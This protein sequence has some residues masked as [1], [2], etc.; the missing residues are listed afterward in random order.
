[1]KPWLEDLSEEWVPQPA[2]PAAAHNESSPVAT[3]TSQSVPP[4]PRS[5]L[6][7][8]RHSSGSFSEIQI[9]QVA[10]DVRPPKPRS[11]LAERSR[12]DDDNNTALTASPNA[13][14]APH[15]DQ[16]RSASPSVYASSTGSVVQC[17]TVAQKSTAPSPSKDQNT[18]E[19]RRR[20][21]GGDIGY[22]DQKD[23]FS[24]MGLQNIFQRPSTSAGVFEAPPER[25]GNLNL[26]KNTS[27]MPSSPPP[28][29]SDKQ[30][31]T[32][33]V[34]DDSENTQDDSQIHHRKGAPE[35]Q[36]R[37]DPARS[38]GPLMSDVE[39]A[40]NEGAPRTVSGQIEFENENFSPVYLTNL[41]I[42]AAADPSP[43]FRGSELARRLRHIG[44]PTPIVD[45]QP[46][47][48]GNSIS[49]A[50]TESSFSK[51]QD[52]TLP[53]DLPAGTP[54]LADVGGFVERQRG[55]YSRDNSFR[56]RPLS[57]SPQSKTVNRGKQRDASTSE[58]AL[59]ERSPALNPTRRP[60]E[61][62][63][64]ANS[65]ATP[66]RQN[67]STLL[68]PE[69]PQTAG[70]PLKLFD[71]HDTFTSKRL[72]RRLSQL[73]Y[74][75]ERAIS[76]GDNTESTKV[77]Q[78]TSRLTS[79]E[80]MSMHDILDAATPEVVENRRVETFG[81]GQL[82]GY[83]FPEEFSVFSSDDVTD[84]E[85]LL[86]D[87]PSM[88]VTP[89]GSRQQF[90]FQ[91]NGSQPSRK[92]SHSQRQGLV[93]VSNPF[94]AQGGAV[95]RPVRTRT[96]VIVPAKEL[97][98]HEFA[99]GKRGPTSP[100]KNPTPK[101]RRTL[102]REEEDEDEG[103]VFSD[104]GVGH[105]DNSHVATQS[106]ISRKRK[107][108]R[109]DHAV[110]VAGA[111][112]LAQR[113]ILRPR[114]PT[115][116]QRRLEGVHAEII[117]ATEAFIMSSPKLDT[118]REQLDPV[119]GPDAPSEET[120]AVIVANKV[121]EF[122]MKR[123]QVMRDESRKRSVTTQDFL[124]EAVKIMD[125]IRAK[126]RPTS[127]LEN[128]EETESESLFR[129]EADPEPS[130]PLTFS[131]P[132]SREGRLS[133]WR[134]PNKHELDPSVMS[135]L[136]KFQEKESEEFMGSSIRSLRFSQLKGPISPETDSI[137]VEQNNIRITDKLNR[138]N[139]E[140]P[141]TID[142]ADFHPRE[143]NTHAS[144]ASSLGQTMATNISRKSEH[145]A[146]VAPKAVAH[147]IP[148]QLAGMSYD[149]VNN[150]WFRQKSPTK[151][152]RP[153]EAV[154]T[155]NETEE[156]PFGNI[157]DLTVDET[158]EQLMSKTSPSRPQPTV[159]T[160]VE[161]TGLFE[162]ED[163]RPVTREG[164]NNAPTDTS[165]VPSKASNFGWSYPKTDTRAT[166][167]SEQDPRNGG[168][169]KT[170]QLPTTYPI[171][172]SDEAD[173]EHEIKYFEGRDE[174]TT[175]MPTAKVRDITFSIEQ[176]GLNQ[177]KWEPKHDSQAQGTMW[178]RVGGANSLPHSRKPIQAHAG[179][180][181]VLEESQPR[182]YRVQLSMSVS[183]PLLKRQDTL[184]PAPSSPAKG[185]VT[186]MLSDLPEFTMHQVDE[187][188]LPDRVVVKHDGVRFSKA[189]EDRYAQ[190][191]AELVKAL[192]NV[193]P[194]EPYWEDLRAVNLH[195][196][197]LSNLHRLD[198]FC[199]R[200]EELDV[201]DNTIS[202][203]EG[204]PYSVRRLRVQNNL[205][206]GLTS[207]A[208]LH[209]LQ[210]LDISDN[211]IDS[212]DGLNELVH[213]R[214]LKVDNNRIT[215]LEGVLHLDGL[216]ELSAGGNHVEAVDFMDSEL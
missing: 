68:S 171:P 215:S 73:E 79:L 61:N 45:I 88:D 104:A 49:Q 41:Q 174:A 56:T 188:E 187:C 136:Q 131:R 135:H 91:L 178:G 198:E 32:H 59:L 143:N 103:D 43:D 142:E 51:L 134:E 192:Q 139:I 205:L 50:R 130:S 147:L 146:Y 85:S 190:G 106:V 99:E 62:S 180:V 30:E 122:S 57:P 138:L 118:I 1:M 6:P 120:R 163:Q 93:R 10:K 94:R 133:E 77:V 111:Q 152:H 116:S 11:A 113:H 181:S 195:N 176:H 17:G 145:V 65:S 34:A 29:P 80:E 22:G 90:Q 125:Y 203:V 107:D 216:I 144:S 150:K 47:S 162:V 211:D 191:T 64:V 129:L 110:N 44:S 155:P 121:A 98:E 213:L 189:L 153:S 209:N 16:S 206:T 115:P 23:L 165:S 87:T 114:N 132:P 175:A 55:G 140:I 24:P 21:L 97:S 123:V 70:S 74:K 109:Q 208:S 184:A 207:W 46:A 15:S 182:N 173:V 100:F 159:E 149:H 72:H 14:N 38:L 157:S 160:F 52:E 126:G 12:S 199:Y 67:Y 201:S 108:V 28:W 8:L 39:G 82:D 164:R 27:V 9:R 76:S 25:K 167:W 212:L 26:F 127:G 128:L 83:A 169:Q 66:R 185:D 89:P 69:R 96:P 81:H 33:Q 177:Q 71:A 78:K 151:E 3:Q 95:S 13:P 2:S 168:T 63:N 102:Q 7:R 48:E 42:G 166:S 137:V 156:D 141:G 112:I 172:E 119:I 75:S 18:P 5:R 54:D 196:K 193:E 37:E 105:E 186:F 58:P 86:D 161:D 36:N 19:W 31:D 53:E 35:A 154:T 148:K 158:V 170:R 197:G 40:D 194:D 210:H 183:A 20:L 214:T 117:E 4:K 92:S 101:R 179:D 60:V 204:I 202:H 200:L 124:D 84:E